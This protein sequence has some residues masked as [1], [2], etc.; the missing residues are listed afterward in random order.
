MTAAIVVGGQRLID[1]FLANF[2]QLT[3]FLTAILV[4][5]HITLLLLFLGTLLNNR[6]LA[7]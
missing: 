4:G 3:A 1:K 5:R 2:E 6:V 7:A